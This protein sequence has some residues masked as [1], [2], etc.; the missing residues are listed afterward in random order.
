MITQEQYNDAVLSCTGGP[1]WDIVKQGFANDIYQTQC[2]ALEA[3]DWGEVC[4]N[5]G[6]ARGLAYAMNLREVVETSMNHAK[7]LDYA[8]V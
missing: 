6:F 3:K 2:Q 5:R 1:E 7:E 8:D 4:E